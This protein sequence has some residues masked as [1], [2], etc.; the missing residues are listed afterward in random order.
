MTN[1]RKWSSSCIL[2]SFESRGEI[3]LITVFISVLTVLPTGS[4]KTI[5]NRWKVVL[6]CRES[7]ICWS[8]NPVRRRIFT[9]SCKTLQQGH[10]G[11]RKI[12]GIF[13]CDKQISIWLIGKEAIRFEQ[14]HV[15][16]W[17]F[18]DRLIRNKRCYQY[19]SRYKRA[20]FGLN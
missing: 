15:V 19:I 6:P 13:I 7:S 14:K 1:T 5:S 4:N 9:R 16:E 12:V 20:K 10:P 2:L 17:P 11:R 8:D 3:V 18:F